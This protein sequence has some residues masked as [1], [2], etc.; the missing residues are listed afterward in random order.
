MIREGR[1]QIQGEEAAGDSSTGI[2]E[3]TVQHAPDER[4]DTA[5]EEIHRSVAQELLDKIAQ[6]P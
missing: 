3:V 2:G 1:S 6:A 4:I 5:L